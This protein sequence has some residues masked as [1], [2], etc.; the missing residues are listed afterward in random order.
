MIYTC[1][2]GFSTSVVTPYV[3]RG[4]SIVFLSNFLFI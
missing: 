1:N 3:L 4:A 2:P